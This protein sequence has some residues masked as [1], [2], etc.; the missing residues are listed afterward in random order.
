MNIRLISFDLDD[1]LW[2]CMPTIEAAEQAV[3][4]WIERD[5]PGLAAATNPQGL[6]DLRRTMM[7]NDPLLQVNLT[8]MRRLFYQHLVFQHGLPE[9][10]VEQG[11]ALFLEWRNRVEPF[12]EVSEVLQQLQH[13]FALAALSNGNADIF[14]TGLG[15]YFHYRLSAA[16]VMSAKPE[17]EMFA[18]LCHQS[19]L[20]P[21]QILHVGDHP[22]H[23][24]LGAQNSGL[25]SAWINREGREWP[26][27]LALHPD[28]QCQNL[29]ELLHHPWLTAELP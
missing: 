20:P 15:Q 10:F 24:I 16:E 11:M 4:E 2:P 26:Q 12:A 7:R 5:Y 19:G 27:E 29:N 1:T 18:A 9:A 25:K 14:Q 17:P 8:Q 6:M 3:W 22:R 13:R 23:D 28:I 21:Q